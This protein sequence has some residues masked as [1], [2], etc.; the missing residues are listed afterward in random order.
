M[1][2][3]GST[4][5][6]GFRNRAVSDAKA[7]K[8]QSLAQALDKQRVDSVNEM[9]RVSRDQLNEM[10]RQDKQ[11]LKNDEYELKNLAK[12]SKTLNDALEMSAKTLGKAYI[13][14]KRQEGIDRARAC[15]NGDEEA[16]AGIKL[17]NQQVLDIE[18][19]IEEMRNKSTGTAD[20]IEL[21]AE[22][23]KV[24]LNLEERAT[25][26]NIRKLGSNVAYGYRQGML[27]ERAKGY[28]AY[29]KSKLLPEYAE[30]G[31]TR[32]DP[33]IT[34]TNEL[35]E[36]VQVRT[37]DFDTSSPHIQEQIIRNLETGFIELG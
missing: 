14:T 4:Q 31:T 25:A 26:L 20:Q 10:S 6:V 16:C 32:I 33:V 13:D 29:L 22:L 35:G 28:S 12:F 9:Q 2:Y 1:P 36:K 11:L 27:Q 23:A 5:S 17:S 30:D 8:A 19:K 37:G 15:N 7:T 24:K 34:V 21:E 3:Q 18:A